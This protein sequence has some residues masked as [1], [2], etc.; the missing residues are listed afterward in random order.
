[1]NHVDQNPLQRSRGGEALRVVGRRDCWERGDESDREETK[2]QTG[3]KK[4]PAGS[5]MAANCETAGSHPVMVAGR[6]ATPKGERAP[7]NPKHE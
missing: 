1:V 5:W 2:E 4:S 7:Q 6:G 3:A